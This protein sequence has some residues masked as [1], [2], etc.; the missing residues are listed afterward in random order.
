MEAV[1]GNAAFVIVMA[2]FFALAYFTSGCAQF[3]DTVGCYA[4]T[5]LKL[6]Y[7]HNFGDSSGG[8][9]SGNLDPAHGNHGASSFRLNQA[10][11]FSEDRIETDVTVR[12]A[13]GSCN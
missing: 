6:G 9:L 10:D 7:A 5:D 8:G 1:K 4:H 3:R 13:P 2:L 12:F 11:Q